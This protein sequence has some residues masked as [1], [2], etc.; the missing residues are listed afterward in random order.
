[1]LFTDLSAANVV[2]K[3]TVGAQRE[4]MLADQVSKIME[5]PRRSGGDEHYL[6]AG[7]LHRG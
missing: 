2:N 3:S 6:H 7:P 4:T 1:M 5:P